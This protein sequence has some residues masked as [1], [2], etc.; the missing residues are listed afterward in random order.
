MKDI[1]LRVV[2]DDTVVCDDSCALLAQ[3]AHLEVVGEGA[4]SMEALEK[5]TAWFRCRAYGRRHVYRGWTGSDKWNNNRLWWTKVLAL[6]QYGDR[7][8]GLTLV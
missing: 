4:K 2:N 7:E 8:C 6:T 3:A 1:R 5:A